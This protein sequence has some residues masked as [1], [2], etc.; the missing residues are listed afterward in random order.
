MQ[1][2]R[3][4]VTAQR[5]QNI[6][7]STKT[8]PVIKDEGAGQNGL[9][10]RMPSKSLADWT[11]DGDDDDVNGYYAGEKRQR[12]GRKK[13]KKTKQEIEVIQNWDD[14]YDPSRPNVFEDYKN[15][16]EKVLE[17]QEWK[18]RLYA[19][20]H[21]RRPVVES[22]SESD[23]ARPIFDRMLMIASQ[24]HEADTATER[25]APPPQFSTIPLNKPEDALI[26]ES[27]PPPPPPLLPPS[28]DIADL[29]SGQGAYLRRPR[30][31]YQIQPLLPDF[32]AAVELDIP[33]PPPPPSDTVQ[34][35]FDM[36]QAAPPPP[37]P[38]SNTAARISREP[39]RYNLPLA[40]PELP[41]SEAE[42]AQALQDENDGAVA[43]STDFIDARS[44][45]P[46]QKGFAER[47]MSKYGWTKGSGLGASGSGITAPLRVQLEKQ[48]KKSDAE[49]GGYATPGGMGKIIGGKRKG[50]ADAQDSRFGPMSEVV[51]LRGM[52]DGMDIDREIGS[53]DGGIMQEI[54]EECGEKVRHANSTCD[55]SS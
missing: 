24:I 11:A 32:P 20:R 18:E 26:S 6:V 48:K 30:P 53:D 52:L 21:V 1:K 2:V 27:P 22:D 33:P 3:P 28:A 38:V 7:A 37:P 51:V 39:V 42:L 4:K 49:G 50:V 44:A 45:R 23:A 14:I 36:P 10:S 16:D 54:G 41:A 40:P 29:A 17:I 31:L 9:V 34:I 55:G 25:F 47:L 13:R 19:H 15:S 5:T 8:A 46:G 12:G 35:P 43:S